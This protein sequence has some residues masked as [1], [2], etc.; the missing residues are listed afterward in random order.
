MRHMM[1]VMGVTAVATATAQGPALPV[2]NGDFGAELEGTWKAW[3]EAGEMTRDGG[4]G[5]TAPGA[6]RIGAT[7]GAFGALPAQALPVQPGDAFK[8][9]AW[10]KAE[11]AG[12]ETYALLELLRDGAPVETPPAQRRVRGATPGWVPVWHVLDVPA[13]SPAT[14]VRIALRSDGNPGAVW[15]DDV[16]LTRLPPDAPVHDGPPA[17]P[18]HGI[19]TARDGHLVGADGER[20]RLW[21]VNCVDE[22]GRDYRQITHIVRR[23]KRMG[24]NAVRLHLYDIRLIDTDAT[25]AAGEPTSRVFRAPGERGDGSVLDRMDYFIYRAQREGLYLYLTLDRGRGAFRPGDYDIL[26]SA[27]PEDEAAWKEAV[28][29][30][31]ERWANEH[32][33]FVDERL[34]AVHAEFTRKHLEHRNAYTGAR[35]ADDPFVALWELTNENGFPKVMLEGGFRNWP[36]YFQGKLQGRWNE[37]LRERYET[38]AR[39]VEAW[40]ALGEGEALDEGSIAAAPVSGEADRHPAARVADFRRFVYDLTLAHCRRLEDIIRGAGSVSAHTPITYDTIFEHKHV[41]YYPMSQ[42]SFQAVGT[43]VGGSLEMRRE[44]SWFREPPRHIYNYSNATVADKPIVVYEN[45]I[46]KPAAD[47]A[48]YPMF[49]STFASARDWDG[50]F[51]Y[52]WSDGTVP[53]QV[54]DEVYA[55]TGLRYAAPSHIWHGIVIATDEVLLA[56]LRLAGELFTRFIIPP[57][58][59]PVIITAGAGDLFGRT[60]W[61]G[62]LDVPFPADAPGPYPRSAA[63]GATDF[64]F[65]TRYRYDPDQA[66]SSVSRPLIAHTPE[67]CSPAPGLTYDYERGV[68]IVDRPEARAVVGFTDGRWEHGGGLSVEAGEAP[69]F[70]HGIVSLDGLPLTESRNALL[71]FTTYGENRGRALREN[72]DEVTAGVPHYAKLVSGWGWGPADIVRP[73]LRMQLP[74]TFDVRALDFSLRPLLTARASTIELPAGQNLFWAELS[75]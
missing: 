43:Y 4:E 75:R 64:A 12:G 72:P 3:G 16:T 42:G 58:P 13:D 50:V 71:V 63:M 52:V 36:E 60:T 53:D 70:C 6:L 66:R 19:I 29:A 47:R 9:T 18:P 65:T 10:V 21:G 24:F 1:L 57:A 23:I 69:F 20:V 56:S 5:R 46:N 44:T 45:N 34:G 30:T 2:A 8:V 33:Y 26:P 68:I 25:T 28:A 32:L 67:V 74:Q 31:N 49:V 62:D 51:W 14:Q 54:D 35:V 40:D 37:W 73:A 22:M 61:I 59:E 11:E 38:Q 55:H 17:P 48:Y 27:G 41:W 15:F 39:L 7:T